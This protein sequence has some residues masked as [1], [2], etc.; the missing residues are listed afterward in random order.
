MRAVAI[1]LT[2][3]LLAG[4]AAD[5]EDQVRD[6]VAA[7]TEAANGR[8]AVGLRSA[9][10]RLVVAVEAQVSAGELDAAEGARI[11]AAAR[12]VQAGADLVDQD[13]IDA[14]EA[15][16]LEAEE[17]ARLAAEEAARQAQEEAQRQAEE[18]A[19]EADKDKKKKDDEDEEEDG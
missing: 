5:G 4:C 16:R 14:E 1:A 6:N 2:A 9:V 13:L 10:D 17:A 7:V 11:V 15:A 8:D 18:A 12:Q 3:V 19:R